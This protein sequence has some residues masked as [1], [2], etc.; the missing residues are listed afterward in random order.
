MHDDEPRD[1]DSK[2]ICEKDIV[3]TLIKATDRRV[4]EWKLKS[5]TYIIIH[6][7]IVYIYI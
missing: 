2:T 6:Y 4:V 5:I 7:K 1:T 3:D